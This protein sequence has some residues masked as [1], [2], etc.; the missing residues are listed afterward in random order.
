MKGVRNHFRGSIPS[1]AV[2][3]DARPCLIHVP[4]GEIV[5]SYLDL[6]KIVKKLGWKVFVNVTSKVWGAWYLPG[7]DEC[8]VQTVY[9]PHPHISAATYSQLSTLVYAFGLNTFAVSYAP[10]AKFRELD[11]CSASQKPVLRLK[12]NGK[13]V[14]TMRF[15]TQI[16]TQRGWK[17]EAETEFVKQVTRPASPPTVLKLPAVE[18]IQQ[19]STLDLEYITMMT[20]NIF[21]LQTPSQDQS[22][23]MPDCE[24]TANQPKTPAAKMS[25]LSSKDTTA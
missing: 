11:D 22:P 13:Q 6:S 19:L 15:F 12:A 24:P 10:L 20:K 1:A 16:L 23:R 5:K 9:L 7:G 14:F 17:K 18:D 2:T 4:T 8:Y 25:T 21:Y 3:K